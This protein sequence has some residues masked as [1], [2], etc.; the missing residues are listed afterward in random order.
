MGCGRQ[1]SSKIWWLTVVANIMFFLNGNAKGTVM[2]TNLPSAPGVKLSVE[3]HQVVLQNGIVNVT[4]S[5]PDGLV[6]KISYN[7]LD[8]LLEVG[9][10]DDDRGYWDVVWTKSKTLDYLKGASYKVEVEN[11][12]QV[13]ISF[14]KKWDASLNGKVVPLNVDKRFVMLRGS[15]GFYTYAVLEHAP[16][17]P[18]LDIP[19]ARVVFKLQHDKFHYM[20]VSDVKQRLMPQPVD[21]QTGQ[22][23]D[24]PEAV[25]LTKPVDPIFKGEVDDK[26]F[27]AGDNFD[28]RVYGWVCSDPTIGFWM[29][30][31]SNE[32]RNGGP[33]KQ[34]LTTHVGPTVLNMFVS[35]HYAGDEL[36]LQ[37]A[38][39]ETWK[40]VF[41][42]VFVYLNS[43]VKAK[44]NPSLLWQ[45]AKQRMLKEVEAWP[46]TFPSSKDFFK[47]NQRGTVG[48]Q[49]QVLDKF[50][51][52]APVPGINAYVGL[53][54]PGAEG[55]WQRES[56]GY[57]FWTKTDAKGNFVIKGIIP[58]KY[59]LYASVPGFIGD[60]KHSQ[61]VTITPGSNVNLG[62]LV[63]KPPRN[64]PTLWEIGVPDRTTG[65]FFVPEPEPTLKVHVF[66]TGDGE[67][68][69]YDDK[70]RQY[71]LW[72][73]YN[74]LYP[75]SD[76]VYTVGVSN[77]TKDWF[78]AQVQRCKD[79]QTCIGTTWQIVFNLQ[80]LITSGNYTLQLALASASFAELQV[81]FNDRNAAPL[82]TGGLIGRD[83]AVARHGTH[84]LYWLFS[85]GVPSNLLVKG[86]NTIFLT[87]ARNS[88]QFR[89]FMYDYIRFEAPAAP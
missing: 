70:F 6:T 38:S 71:G 21:R 13:E 66:T 78:Y 68:G 58:G 48:G 57:Q 82:F 69:T 62:N 65:E 23:L 20:A 83:N 25:L 27:Y 61:D 54:A 67:S 53:A 81:R 80:N 50:T 3:D 2:G 84:G 12:N 19:E 5:A 76:L 30:T 41:G 86:K 10:E 89:G 1:W 46:Y 18:D 79:K 88:D 75:T 32:F 14:T 72:K 59:S 7:G 37:F 4:L 29:I 42:P 17:M 43:D 74:D 64:G 22:V 77:H 28:N 31:P 15:A 11:E 47:P 56:K 33:F 8:N 85:I 39:G 51:N 52:K 35:T 73:R 63:Y 36:A 16:G 44:E 55:S 9:N 49:L 26:Y 45:D 87:Q 24:F 34:D 40:K 60:F